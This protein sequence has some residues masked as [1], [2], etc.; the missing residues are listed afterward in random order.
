MS[1]FID[2]IVEKDLDL[3]SKLKLSERPIILYGTGDGADKIIDVLKSKGI[4]INGVFASD[5]FKKGKIFR[6]FEVVGFKEICEKFYDFTVLLSFA[7]S[8]E[9]VIS[10]VCRISE[11]VP[12]FAPDVPVFGD[13]L[14]DSEYFYD[15]INRLESIYNSL[16]DDKSRHTFSCAINYRLSGNIKYLFECESDISEQYNVFMTKRAAEGYV[17]IGAYNGDTVS[18]FCSYFGKNIPISAFEPDARN[19]KKM[20][21]RF[22]AEKICGVNTHNIAAWNESAELE[23]FSRSGRNSSTGANRN[24]KRTLIPANSVDNILSHSCGVI[25]I[26]AEGAEKQVLQGLAQTIEK[27]KPVLKIA[28]YHRTGDYFEIPEQVLALNPDYKMYMRHLRYIPC[29]DTDF[30]FI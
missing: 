13:G 21:A 20:L 15:N 16:A 2:S 27:Y 12:V 17:D 29:W 14:F 7:S 28:A 18:Q 6:G 1:K 5:G 30:I 23:F 9:D 24:L 4:G 10:N 22:E 19:F 26:D 25:K 3:W 8:L 11:K